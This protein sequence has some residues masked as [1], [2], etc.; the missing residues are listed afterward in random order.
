[1]IKYKYNPPCCS[2]HLDDLYLVPPG[3]LV[4]AAQPPEV[5]VQEVSR[6]AEGDEEPAQHHRHRPGQVHGLLSGE[7]S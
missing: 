7:N 2:R 3:L 1:M 5:F 4:V 6:G